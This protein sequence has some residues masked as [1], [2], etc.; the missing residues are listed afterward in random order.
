MTQA[1]IRSRRPFLVKAEYYYAAVAWPDAIHIETTLL[2][3]LLI[4]FVYW[5]LKGV[6]L[7]MWYYPSFHLYRL[8]LSLSYLCSVMNWHHDYIL[9]IQ[10]GAFTFDTKRCEVDLTDNFWMPRVGQVDT[11][12]DH[13]HSACVHGLLYQP[14]PS[15]VSSDCDGDPKA[16]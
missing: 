3:V 7:T 11:L 13:L 4:C 12:H 14:S 2:S 9:G 16:A 10:L 1:S 15:T 8:V 6:I 5:S